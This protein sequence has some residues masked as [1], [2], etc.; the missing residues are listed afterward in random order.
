[1][2]LNLKHVNFADFGVSMRLSTFSVFNQPSQMPYNV[3]FPT[4]TNFPIRSRYVSYFMFSHNTFKTFVMLVTFLPF[5][6]N[7]YV[8]LASGKGLKNS[9]HRDLFKAQNPKQKNP[10][11][12]AVFYAPY[13]AWIDLVQPI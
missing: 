13:G 12:S 11:P 7:L 6:S 9:V 8:V 1:M 2:S 10:R 3:I 5:Q 4:E